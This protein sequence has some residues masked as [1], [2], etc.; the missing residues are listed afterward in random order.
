MLFACGDSL[1]FL[2]ST[3]AGHTWQLS[4]LIPHNFHKNYN[5]INFLNATTGYASYNESCASIIYTNNGGTTWTM[6]PVIDPDGNVSTLPCGNYTAFNSTNNLIKGCSGINTNGGNGFPLGSIGW[7]NVGSTLVNPNCGYSHKLFASGST[8]FLMDVY[9]ELRKSV[10]NGLS[11]TSLANPPSIYAYYPIG[12]YFTN[13]STGFITRDSGHIYKT[14]DGGI[15]WALKPTGTTQHINDISFYNSSIGIAVG[16]SG[17]ILKTT[18]GGDTWLAE[19]CSVNERLLGITFVNTADAVIV[20][21]NGTI[22]HN[23]AAN[24]WPGDANNDLEANNFDLLPIGLHYNETGPPRASVSNLWQAYSATNWG[25]LQSNCVDLKHADCNGDG[26]I[27]S[28]DTTAIVQNF[29]LTHP[30][31]HASASSVVTNPQLYFVQSS[32]S[33]MPGQWVD[34]EVWTGDAA[35]VISD[36]YGIAYDIQF[37]SAMVEP[38]TTSIDYSGS[39]AGTNGTNAIVLSKVIEPSGEAHSA[40][41]R[42]VHTDTSGYG[43]IATLRF[44]TN[45]T[46]SSLTSFP[47]IITVNSKVSSNGQ[48]SFFTTEEDTVTVDPLLGS[49]EINTNNL[50]TISPNPSSGKFIIHSPNGKSSQ[51]I[52]NNLSGQ[53]IYEKEFPV[54]LPTATNYEIDLTDQPKGIYFLEI[55][56]ADGSVVK[57]VVVI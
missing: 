20:G 9:G 17:T 42:T 36:L 32:P 1:T 23:A 56:I 15:T 33:Y 29:G 41:C 6:I 55:K 31:R 49:T 30:F 25:P 10:N 38:G 45:T 40:F 44:M 39:W 43:K 24:V 22:L 54:S 4:Y 50:I 46:I 16:D 34:M 21:E 12:F 19:S 11:W 18:D 2:K 48:Y 14:I 28:D 53:T 57:K 26:I 27:N 47:I 13:P 51:I 37:S 35:N 5:N 52:I 3:D 7:L 8:I